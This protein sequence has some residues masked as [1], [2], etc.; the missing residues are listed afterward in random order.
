MKNE[1]LENLIAKM[2]LKNSYWGYLFSRVR[3]RPS[4]IIPSIMGVAPEKDGTVSLYYHPQLLELTSDDNVKLVLEHEGLHLLNKHIPRCI[5][6]IS[7]ETREEY[8]TFKQMI[9]NIAAD[10]CVNTQMDMPKSIEIGGSKFV[11]VFPEKYKLPIKK[12]TEYYYHELLKQQK[13]CPKCGS[14]GIGK[15]DCD[16]N[17]S[18]GEG[19]LDD[20]GDWSDMKGVSDPHALSRNIDNYV[21]D[22]IKE[23]AKNFSNKRGLLPGHIAELIEDALKPPAAPYYQIIRKLVKGSR[24]TKFQRCPTR[25]NRKRTYMFAI[26]ENNNLPVLSPFPGKK[27][28]FTFHITVLLDSSGSMSKDDI[29]EGLSGI[30][31]IIEKDRYCTTCVI[32]NDTQVRK[33]YEVK[34]LRDI[35]FDIKGRG[36]TTLLPGLELARENKTDVVLVFTDGYCEDINSV[37]RKLLPKKIIWVITNHGTATNVNQTGFVITL[38]R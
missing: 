13:E 4:E 37:P 12:T 5:R 17:E 25:L 32:E 6:L 1:R 30:A 3:R 10:C 34:R 24:L 19:I 33:E 38:K 35:Q 2:V 28:D 23:S 36:G 27:R 18:L 11:P 20:H 14:V 7:D 26:G 9:F 22:I 8:K 21:Q 15:C 29:L 31:S 16:G